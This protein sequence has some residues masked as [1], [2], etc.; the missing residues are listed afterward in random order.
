[1]GPWR[2][3]RF[4]LRHVSFFG[5]SA[6]GRATA[7]TARSPEFVQTPPPKSVLQS[8]SP[9]HEHSLPSQWIVARP[10]VLA[11][12]IM[13][14]ARSAKTIW[15]MGVWEQS[16][17]SPLSSGASNESGKRIGSRENFSFASPS[18]GTSGHLV[19]Q[20]LAAQLLF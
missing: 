14:A 5:T 13:S 2:R 18:F 1:M 19:P 12:P 17:V 10:G 16:F 11:N 7:A 6:S 20:S 8:S 3:S 4:G 9:I 15:N